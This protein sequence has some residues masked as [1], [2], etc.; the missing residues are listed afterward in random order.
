M[1]KHRYDISVILKKDSWHIAF[2]QAYIN[3][4]PHEHDTN[5]TCIKL[6]YG[7]WCD[8]LYETFVPN[9]KDG[10]KINVKHAYVLG[11]KRE[12]RHLKLCVILYTVHTLISTF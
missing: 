12:Y 4:I 8:S 3:I 7:I 2:I 9:C 10:C 11:G 1:F 6:H 5:E